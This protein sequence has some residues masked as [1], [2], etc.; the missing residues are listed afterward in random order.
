MKKALVVALVL[1]L[2]AMGL[3][4]LGV[5][6][7][8]IPT[9]GSVLLSCSGKS[10]SIVNQDGGFPTGNFIGTSDPR[11]FIS[12]GCISQT[13]AHTII[14]IAGGQDVVV[15][16]EAN[17]EATEAFTGQLK[18]TMAPAG[19]GCASPDFSAQFLAGLPGAQTS[20]PLTLSAGCT[21]KLVVQS[22]GVGEFDAYV[23]AATVTPTSS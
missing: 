8:A 22:S 23:Q 17:D 20:D 11:N 14:S 18:A 5:G 1:A 10:A 9:D 19:P 3:M 16:L 7:A 6:H 21:Y 15:T 4:L 13:A 2:G 12:N